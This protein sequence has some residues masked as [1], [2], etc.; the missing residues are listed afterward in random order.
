MESRRGGGG[1]RLEKLDG[2]W[3]LQSRDGAR[4]AAVGGSRALWETFLSLDQVFGCPLCQLGCTG[5]RVRGVSRS[6]E[7]P[8]P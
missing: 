4:P 7:R 6:G 8:E 2:A 5:I 3:D 1:W